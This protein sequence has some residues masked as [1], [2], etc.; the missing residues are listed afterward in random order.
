MTIDWGIIFKSMPL[1]GHGVVVTLQVSA[2][3]SVLGLMLGV[4]LGEIINHIFQ[5][6]LTVS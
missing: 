5:N 6:V 4:V 1:L 2:L 3:A